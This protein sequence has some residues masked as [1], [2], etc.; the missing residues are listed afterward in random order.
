MA[1]YEQLS[2]QDQ[3]QEQPSGIQTSEVD[4]NQEL[5]RMNISTAKV[6]AMKPDTKYFMESS[7][8]NGLLPHR[9]V[10]IKKKPLIKNGWTEVRK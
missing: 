8:W 3:H 4:R 1:S 5:Q 10:E 7:G 2:I 6:S 9:A